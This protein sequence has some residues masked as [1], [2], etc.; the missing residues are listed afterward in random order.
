MFLHSPSPIPPFSPSVLTLRVLCV[1]CGKS[2]NCRKT[3]VSVLDTHVS[4]RSCKIRFD[5]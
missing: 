5:S 2:W 1:L 3:P 4:L